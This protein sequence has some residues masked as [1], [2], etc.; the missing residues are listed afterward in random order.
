MIDRLRSLPQF[1]HFSEEQLEMLRGC[2]FRHQYAEGAIV[3]QERESTREAFILESGS[4]SLQRETSYG[5][6]ELTRLE[7]G[8]LFGEINFVDGDTRS[9]NAVAL[10]DCDLLVL[11]P[12][13]LDQLCADDPAFEVAL[14]W[15]L[16]KSLS[17]KLRTTNQN[18][19][20]FFEEK[21]DDPGVLPAVVQTFEDAGLDIEMKRTL[22][23]EAGLSKMETNFLASLC[24][25]RRLQ[26]HQQVFTEGDPGD[27]MY[28]VAEGRVMISKMI[29]GAG[30]EALAFLGRGEFFGEMALI[31]AAPR[32]ADAKADAGGAL[33]LAIRQ[34]VL[35]KI[36]DIERA[37]SIRLLRI[38]TQILAKRLRESNEKIIGWYILSGGSHREGIP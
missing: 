19:A 9:V 16:W 8:D 38:L 2:A 26:P 17:A 3:I 1:K 24:E 33:V 14:T 32:C 28:L 10:A 12:I 27:R 4:I 34:D 36:L 11:N 25:A 31:D 37:S 7:P 13:R 30:E 5:Q 35:S 22:F 15:T 21:Q 20:A 23:R 29:P 18:L 6:F